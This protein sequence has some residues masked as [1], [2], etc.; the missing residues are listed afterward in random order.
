MLRTNAENSSFDGDFTYNKDG[1]RSQVDLCIAN[2]RAMDSIT[3]FKIHQLPTNFSDHC[4]I[5]TSLAID[6][7]SS[8]SSS[9]VLTDILSNNGDD[10][11]MKRPRKLPTN[12]NWEAYVNTASIDL[13]K[14]NEELQQTDEFTQETVDQVITDL[15]EIITKSAK[16]CEIKTTENLPIQ[17]IRNES[18][19]VEQISA[20][21]SKKEI[22]SWNDIMASANPG[23]IW[24]KVNWK[25]KTDEQLQY[26][27]AESLGEHFQEKSTISNETPFSLNTNS[28]YVPV[29]DDPISQEELEVASRRLKDKAT[30][31]KA[32]VC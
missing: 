2:E 15:N 16:S 29:L 31:D 28:P 22:D 11:N 4:P 5:S 20:G 10:T 18:L 24:K 26:P 1:K 30:S 8:I 14:L 32:T 3:S 23:D 12:I 13:Q 9:Q 27:S 17:H 21:I 25:D 6:M 19:T 7:T